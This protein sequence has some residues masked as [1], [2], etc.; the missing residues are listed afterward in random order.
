MI[1]GSDAVSEVE[2]LAAQLAP[3][4]LPQRLQLAVSIA[5]TGA[6]RF[7]T[8]FGLEDQ[9][10]THAI[11]L[12]APEI[13]IVTIDTGR[14]F[15]ETHD[16]WAETEARYRRRIRAVAPDREQVEIFVAQN[17]IN[18]FRD[19]IENRLACCGI[20]KG[21]PL[22]RALARASAWIT[23]LRTEQS[24]HRR[25]TPLAELDDEHTL[26]K[27]NPLADWTARD[28]ARYIADNRI[29]YNAL[30][31]RGFPSIGCAPCTRAVRIGESERAGRWWW[32]EDQKKECGL[33]LRPVQN[34]NAATSIVTAE[35]EVA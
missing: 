17:G 9:V 16:V 4:S 8:S 5:C 1:A 20:R 28:V 3:L 32:E 29:P 34:T 10:I 23:G 18:G 33:H 14:L 11:M 19:S 31:D 6:V 15:P 27:I 25:S 13:E 2:S 26:I 24:E 35:K 21:E 22:R 30:H 12:N 7:T